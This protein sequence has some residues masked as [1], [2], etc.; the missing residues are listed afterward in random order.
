LVIGAV[1]VTG[2]RAPKL[3][4]RDHLATMKRGAVI[5]DVAVDQGGCAETSR[6]TTHEDPVFV[7]DG[8]VHYCVSNMP[9]A[10]ALSSTQALTSTTL[11]YGLLLAQHGVHQACLRH[12]DL[13]RGLNTLGGACV[14]AGVAEACGLPYTPA[15]EALAR[16]A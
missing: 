4:R 15:E 10:V 11:P 6:P 7:V 8:I 5:V 2:G 12:P 13:C 14:Y 16:T 1:L 3:I 9:G